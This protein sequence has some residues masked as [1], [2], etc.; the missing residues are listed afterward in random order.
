MI[1]LGRNAQMSWDMEM[2]I[3][4]LEILD[5]AF[6]RDGDH[7]VAEEVNV[8]GCVGLKGRD[9]NRADVVWSQAL[10]A[11]NVL[12][13]LLLSADD[14]GLWIAEEI[15]PGFVHDREVLRRAGVDKNVLA[16]ATNK[17]DENVHLLALVP[18][19]HPVDFWSGNPEGAGVEGLY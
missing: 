13:Q 7:C 18:V 12:R 11:E 15:E 8:G 17:V 4:G 16:A 19:F 3:G 9:Y 1:H 5:P 14:L 2:I 6:A 10:I